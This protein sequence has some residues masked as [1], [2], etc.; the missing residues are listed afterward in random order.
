MGKKAAVATTAVILCAGLAVGGYIFWNSGEKDPENEVNAGS[1]T[2]STTPDTDPGAAGGSSGI[3]G[4][5]EITVSE[6]TYFYDNHEISY[7][8]LI[9]LLDGLDENTAVKISDEN[10]AL[11]A[12]ENLTKALEEREILY[13]AAD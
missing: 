2:S 11:K 4:Y 8:E 13:E 6:S 3:A 12:Y 1:P 7:D 5:I 9:E 10:A